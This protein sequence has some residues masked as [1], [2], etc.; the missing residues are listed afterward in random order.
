MSRNRFCHTTIVVLL[1]ML[2]TVG[3]TPVFA[4][5]ILLKGTVAAVEATRIQIRTGEESKGH[6]PAWVIVSSKTIVLRD[7]TP[8]TFA[9][10][11]IKAGERVVAKVDHDADGVLK[12]LEIRLA[13]KP[14]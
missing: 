9:A 12:A 1:L 11:K 5:Q 14:N 4:H 3:G 2:S 10:A 13:A 7:K 6:A 8:V